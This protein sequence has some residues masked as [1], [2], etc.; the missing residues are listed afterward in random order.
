MVEI[1]TKAGAEHVTLDAAQTKEYDELA[2]EVKSI[3]AHIGRLRDLEAVQTKA[4][5]RI[6]PTTP[7]NQQ[8]ELR[9]GAPVITVK[10][11]VPK[12]TAFVRSCMAILRSRGDSLR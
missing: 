2:D 3:D 9:G 1:M 5:T 6:D 7:A 11:N 4:A 10:S 8:T 12:G